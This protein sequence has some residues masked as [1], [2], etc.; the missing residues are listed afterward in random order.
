MIT[1]L[2]RNVDGTAA[3]TVDR[4]DETGGWYRYS[5]DFR[6]PAELDE[7]MRNA[8]AAVSGISVNEVEQAK[9]KM[10]KAQKAFESYLNR[11]FIDLERHKKLA[12]ALRIAIDDFIET[13]SAGV[14]E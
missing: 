4:G 11:G 10:V 13:V 12:E 14:P 6:Y 5:A 3:S 1:C 9:S 7:T 2:A 8:G